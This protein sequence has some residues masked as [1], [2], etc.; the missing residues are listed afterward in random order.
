MGSG[1]HVG[2]LLRAA[3]KGRYRGAV[4][5]REIDAELDLR[6]STLEHWEAGRVQHLPIAQVMALAAYLEIPLEDLQEAAL[7]DAS[8]LR[9]GQNSAPASLVGGVPGPNG[10]DGGKLA[11]SEVAERRRRGSGGRSR[12]R[13]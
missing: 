9:A 11:V 3:R 2:V 1:T 10:R 4:G 6:K 8:E 5:F 7:A 12:Q 13:S